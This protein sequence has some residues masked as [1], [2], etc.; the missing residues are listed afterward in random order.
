MHYIYDKYYYFASPSMLEDNMYRYGKYIKNPYEGIE[1]VDEHEYGE[2]QY[3]Y[4]RQ[5]FTDT[6]LISNIKFYKTKIFELNSKFM[7]TVKNKITLRDLY[8]QIINKGTGGTTVG[9]D[10]I[11]SG[12]YDYLTTNENIPINKLIYNT[13]YLIIDN[14]N[15]YIGIL[16]HIEHI[17]YYAGFP[18]GPTHIRDK[19]TF[20]DVVRKPNKKTIGDIS[21]N[22]RIL[23]DVTHLFYF[24][25]LPPM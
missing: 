15:T 6:I 10:L 1:N 20:T 21:F 12:L 23:N 24:S 14:D 3:N 25:E 2:E 17:H 7:E 4:K 8:A 18:K 22:G 11:K 16:D 19:I 13:Q 5:Y 9:N